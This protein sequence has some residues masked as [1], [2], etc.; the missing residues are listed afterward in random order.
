MIFRF[1]AAF[2]LFMG[3][4]AVSLARPDAQGISRVLFVISWAVAG[5]VVVRDAARN[6]LRGE[7]FDENFL[8]T[9]ASVGALVVGQWSEGAAVMI[10]YNLG[11]LVQE[12]AVRRS[13]RSI[14]ELMD[15][16]PDEAR[17]SS[18]NAIVHPSA[19]AVGTELLV[20]PGERVP[21][22]GTIVSGSSSFDTSSLTGESVP[23]SGMPGTGVLAGFVNGSG[24]VTIKVTASYADTAAAKM[25]ALTEGAQRRK[26]KAE[27]F[28][29]SFA[30]IYTPIVTLSAVA[31]AALPPLVGALLGLGDLSGW[32][33]FRPW[34][35]RALVFLVISCPC[36]F[37][38]SV[39]LGFFGGI[40][41]AAKRGILIKGADYLD[42]LAKTEAVV[43]DKT[44]TLTHG[45]F[46]VH[47]TVPSGGYDEDALV[48][49]AAL[50]ES[51]STHPIAAAI[52]R[53]AESRGIAMS[54]DRVLSSADIPGFGVS[55]SVPE[56]VILAGSER[57]MEKEN[58]VGPFRRNISDE[59]PGAGTAVFVALNGSFAGYIALGDEPKPESAA[60]VAE[61]RALGVRSVVM[62]TGDG[63]AP[64]A[65]VARAVGIDETRAEALP[66]EKVMFFEELSSQIKALS[67]KATTI[68]V[69]DGMNDAPVLARAD[70]GMAMGGMG[71]DAAV[72]A[73]DVVLMN[74]NPRLVA[75]A[76]RVA[77]WTRRIVSEN[78]V[79][80]FSVKIVFL[81]MGAFGVAN[82]WEAVFADVGVALLATLNALRARR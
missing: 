4:I 71:S 49:L 38:I 53:A 35:Y 40:G 52:R 30:K 45:S 11:E 19:V 48:R 82:M 16:R 75:E 34:V 59:T 31:L 46:A 58:V 3:A 74:D 77:R 36:A 2:V 44:G 21:L 28:V 79:L 80:A 60:A 61:L 42:A 1:A 63:S 78:I 76:I 6:A 37:V 68:F 17:L 43:F 22:D 67:P 41:G 32:E 5:A 66:H 18:S 55:V 65:A 20:L 64:A 8:M 81:A 13:R 69:G 24:S 56:G 27:R 62:L 7:L 47:E 9:I 33:S 39:P 73:A 14:V 29:T 57:L 70:V 15:V 54:A 51:R 25:L 50:A 26:A 10:F 72:E 12:T 23:R